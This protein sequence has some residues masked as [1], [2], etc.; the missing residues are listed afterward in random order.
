MYIY[1]YIYICTCA[2][3][4]LR[5]SSG[6]PPSAPCAERGMIWESFSRESSMHEELDDGMF[7]ES[8]NFV[9]VARTR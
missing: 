8:P 6:G 5:S 9:K 7:R 3:A 4:T 2:D 1:I